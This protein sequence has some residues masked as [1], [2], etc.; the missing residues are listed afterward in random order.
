MRKRSGKSTIRDVARLAGVAECT[1]S[2]VLAESPLVNPKTRA[3]VLKAIEELQYYPNFLARS[4]ASGRSNTIGVI[5]SNLANP[6]LLE[7]I[8]TIEDIAYNR[9]FSVTVSS[10]YNQPEREKRYIKF[11]IEKQFDG[12]ILTSALLRDRET[13][14]LL[15]DLGIP[16]VLVN[17]YIPHSSYPYVTSDNH[18]GGYLA[19]E[20]LCKLGHIKIAQIQGP[21]YSAPIRA[22]NEGFAAALDFHGVPLREE[23]IR[24]GDLSFDS[25]HSLTRELLQKGYA[26]DAVFAGNDMMAFGVV[27]AIQGAGLKVPEDISVVGFDDIEFAPLFGDI[28]LTT[29]RQ[30]RGL[31]A[32]RGFQILI[33]KIQNPNDTTVPQVI[34][35]VDLIVR[36]S[37]KSR[38]NGSNL[39]R[40]VIN[41][42]N[43]ENA[44]R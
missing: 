40:E 21:P 16:F 23:L 30:D 44:R 38:K 18:R 4:L 39:H 37:T 22:R 42:R 41:G 12:I 19:G 26:F 29:V 25:G 2:R 6:F 43:R 15:R 3:R 31:M 24:Q 17:R 8:R 1:V 34:L 35:P 27:R 11:F 9:E 32:R 33:D 36:G 20:H 28:G 7:I 5:T 14:N 13:P 10:T